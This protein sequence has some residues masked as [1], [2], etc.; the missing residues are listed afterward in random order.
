[1][2]NIRMV[3]WGLL[4]ALIILFIC[5]L[6][7]VALT[8]LQDWESST[9][10]FVDKM[11]LLLLFV[12]SALLSGTVVLARP[13]HLMFQQRI[14]DGFILLLSTIVWL[15]LMLVCVLTIIVFFDVHTIF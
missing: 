10:G 8:Q 11:T 3:L 12:T 6:A 14:K 1:M 13:A 2:S 7:I 15:V 5:G 9:D 4:Q